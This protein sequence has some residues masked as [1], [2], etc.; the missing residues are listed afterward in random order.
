MCLVFLPLAIVANWLWLVMIVG[1]KPVKNSVSSSF[2]LTIMP[3]SRVNVS[4]CTCESAISVKEGPQCFSLYT[5]PDL[6]VTS[7]AHRCS[8]C[9]PFLTVCWCDVDESQAYPVGIA[10]SVLDSLLGVKL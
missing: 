9:N 2:P 5:W 7:C 6:R 1:L 10:V 8:P 3:L 4:I